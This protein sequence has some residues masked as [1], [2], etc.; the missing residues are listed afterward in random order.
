[1]LG[2]ALEGFLQTCDL[3]TVGCFN[4]SFS[5]HPWSGSAANPLL[6]WGPSAKILNR[7]GHS[8]LL[9]LGL[10]LEQLVVTSEFKLVARSK[11][12]FPALLVNSN[13]RVEET[14]SQ[15]PHYYKFNPS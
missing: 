9:N 4:C 2:L 11:L 8:C 6:V 3:F 5:R 14:R 7:N 10:Y 13:C 1:M 12:P 15:L